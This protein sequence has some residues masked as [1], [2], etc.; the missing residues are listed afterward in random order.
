[1][2]TKI[3]V[4]ED[5]NFEGNNMA[6]GY[7]YSV[8][9]N[10]Q[11][12]ELINSGKVTK[13]DYPKLDSTEMAINSMM[14]LH[15]ETVERIKNDKKYDDA[16]SLRT[17]KLEEVEEE[18]EKNIAKL[19]NDYHVELDAT[20]KETVNK[21]LEATSGEPDKAVIQF[22]DNAITELTYSDNINDNLELLAIKISNLSDEQKVSVLNKFG[23]LKNA[24]PK[25]SPIAQRTLQSIYQDIKGASKTAEYDKQ[26][27][28]L[29]SIKKNYANGVDIDY[30]NYK[31]IK[32]GKR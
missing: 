22:M 19:K 16:E 10:E 13:V 30:R 14:K 27:K 32:G 26:L 29:Q 23:D 21:S 8:Q 31:R 12:N 25:E 3:Y 2:N 18:L 20:I 1:M 7:V 5:V 4:N 24:V 9:S 17:A 6:T 11:L 15:K 28:I